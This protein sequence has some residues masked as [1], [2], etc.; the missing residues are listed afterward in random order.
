M[1]HPIESQ[2]VLL[3]GAKASVTLSRLSELLEQANASLTERRAVYDRRYER[4]DE[5]GERTYYLVDANHWNTLGDELGFNR[6]ES[7]A[8]K[9]AHTEQFRR[10]GRRLDR[11]E[12]FETALEIR[13][14][15]VVEPAD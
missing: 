8:L 7:E 4:I 13:A 9:R 5:H 2:V 6:R 10:A 15:V 1:I 12:E 11:L 14:V 3:A